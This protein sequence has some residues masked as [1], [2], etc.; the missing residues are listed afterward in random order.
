MMYERE[1][2]DLCI[3]AMKP[4]NKPG[5]PG[6]ESVERRRGAEENTGEPRTCRTLSRASVFQRLDRV[7][8]A[9]VRFAV[10]YPRWEPGAR[11][12]PAGICAGGTGQPVSLPRSSGTLGCRVPPLTTGS[13]RVVLFFL[14]RPAIWKSEVRPRRTEF[15]PKPGGYQFVATPDSRRSP[16]LRAKVEAKV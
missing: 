1:K 5:Q 3:V 13:F 8:Q 14:A 16:G 15:G 10:T 2:S 12:A 11:I 6:A 4:A 7:R 9:A